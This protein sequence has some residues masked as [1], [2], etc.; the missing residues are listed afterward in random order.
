VGTMQYHVPCRKLT[1]S[2]VVH[3]HLFES[4]SC[5]SWHVPKQL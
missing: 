2:S 4:F 5:S 1:V 3:P